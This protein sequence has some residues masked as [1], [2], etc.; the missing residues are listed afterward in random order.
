MN[1]EQYRY[2][3]KDSIRK[4]IDF[5]STD[6]S[7]GIKAPPIEKPYSPGSKKFGLVNADWSKHFNISLSEAIK[8]RESRR[9]Y[10][11]HPLTLFE[12][13]FLLWATQGVRKHVG[14]YAFRNVPS[15]GCRHTLETYLAIFNVEKTENGEKFEPGIYRYLPLTHELLFEFKKDHL[16][17]KMIKATFG[18]T[19]VGQSAVTFIWTAIPYRME[20]RY[21]LD[22]H[23]VIAMDAG[24]VGQNMYLACEAI[25]AGTC[26]IGAYDQEYLDDLLHLD[27]KEEFAIYLTPVGNIDKE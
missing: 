11:K 25:G 2:F 13:S 7:K 21:G 9:R 8:N 17:E 5:S 6:Q 24:H 3:L 26:A 20:W 12:L 22:S 4:T 15:A 27:G 16:Q 19:F 1:L 14:D 18:Q 23:K 10:K